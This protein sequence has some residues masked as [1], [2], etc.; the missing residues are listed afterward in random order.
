MNYF[1]SGWIENLGVDPWLLLAFLRLAPIF[2]LLSF[3]LVLVCCV[4][5]AI[6]IPLMFYFVISKSVLISGMKQVV[7]IFQVFCLFFALTSSTNAQEGKDWF[8]S[9][10]EQIEIPTGKLSKFSVGNKQIQGHKHN[11]GSQTLL[12]KAKSIGF[13]DVILWNKKN[14]I[15][16]KFYVSSKKEHLNKMEILQV[17]K[18][19]KL[20][21]KI[22]GDFVKVSGT[23]T[24]VEQY[25]IYNQI[26]NSKNLNFIW[27]VDITKE[28]RNHIYKNIYIE[29]YNRGVKSIDCDVF[30]Q[31]NIE[32][33]YTSTHKIELENLA[34]KYGVRIFQKESLEESK[35][36]QLTL[37]ILMIENKDSFDHSSG[38]D[39]I[40]I[41]LKE[42][43]E[44]NP[45]MATNNILYENQSYKVRTISEQVINTILNEN[46]ESTLGSEIPFKSQSKD[47]IIQTEWKFVGLK[48]KGDLKIK[49]EKFLLNQSS[50]LT[51]PSDNG[52]GGPKSKSILYLDENIPTKVF[53]ID[54]QTSMKANKS[55]PLL[56]SIP[57][58]KHLFGTYGNEN[59]VKRIIGFITL[60]K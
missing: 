35:N 4:F 40:N 53:E 51:A 49:N 21:T 31:T 27:S 22:W 43:L 41:S 45:S 24:N 17:L 7:K 54:F 15:T 59:S 38:F 6:F 32:C 39:Q 5:E 19:T 50:Q 55:I 34:K 9:I 13:S 26:K 8:I 11:P 46:F 16:H 3:L 12:I 2:F 52:V 33:W 44:N 30:E 1:L 25:R 10:G 18:H 14:K 58:L 48:L 23:I 56:G 29:S 42:I 36:Y 47:A 57:V 28:L 20:E 37:K 60:G